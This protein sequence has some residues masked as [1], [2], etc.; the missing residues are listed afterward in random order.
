MRVVR[1]VISVPRQELED[2]VFINITQSSQIV[3]FEPDQ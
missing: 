2:G 1:M 3:V